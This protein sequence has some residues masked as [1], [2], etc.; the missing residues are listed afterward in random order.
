MRPLARRRFR[1]SGGLTLIEIIVVLAIVAIVMGVAVAGSNQLP[2]SRLRRSATMITS[3]IKVAY[4]RA[5]ATSRN[6]RL[7]M[8]LDQQR[9]WLEE[10][11]APMLVQ[12]KDTSGT[13]GAEAVTD[14]ERAARA[15]GDRI[16]K[17]VVVPKPS[18][19]KIATYGFGDDAEAKGTRALQHGI[20]FRAVQTAHDDVP[21]KSGRAYLYFWPGGLTERAAIQ[22]RI[23][24]S[25]EDF[26]T[27]TLVVSPLTGKVAF[28]PGPV[29]L[30]LPQDDEHASDR[31]DNGF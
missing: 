11:E 23:G 25:E 12:S 15:E 19:R 22:L 8:D 31:Q 28:K 13:G 26:R 3:A 2:S 29:E 20:A 4:S 7:V 5:T 9:I 10:S 17:G 21:R 18:F 16:V 1:G 30:Q 6:L 27:L 14:A 24:E